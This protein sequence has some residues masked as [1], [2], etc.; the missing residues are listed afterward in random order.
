MSRKDVIDY[1]Y[2]CMLMGVE[3]VIDNCVI[4]YDIKEDKI[5]LLKCIYSDSSKNY[6][7]LPNF[8]DK[9]CTKSFN[10]ICVDE[11]IGKNVSE[12]EQHV[13]NNCY[14]KKCTFPILSI[15]A[16][17]AFEDFKSLEV[18]KV[19][20]H[21]SYLGKQSLEGT[22]LYNFKT[23]KIDLIGSFA[24]F[25]TPIKSLDI[26]IIHKC[27]LNSFFGIFTPIETQINNG[28]SIKEFIDS[29]QNLLSIDGPYYTFNFPSVEKLEDNL[30]EYI[31][32]KIM[33]MYI[34]Y[35]NEFN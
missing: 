15:I 9:I 17:Y 8:I 34:N 27:Y 19:S 3:S 25:N 7:V 21:L 33:D 20:N 26:K 4:K 32:Q 31:P 13:F 18:L 30:K 10:Y 2:R 11:V 12:V 29:Y 1:C 23:D 6:I 16:N 5:C 14:I 35:Y 22:S 24:F 28:L